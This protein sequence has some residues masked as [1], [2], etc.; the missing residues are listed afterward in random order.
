MGLKN[1]SRVEVPYIYHL[2]EDGP[3]YELRSIVCHTGENMTSG[4]YVCYGRRNN[5]W[6]FFNDSDV[7]KVSEAEVKNILSQGVDRDYWYY[8]YIYVYEIIE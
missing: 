1:T 8:P 4:H 6:Y 2:G 3:K 7:K 5:E